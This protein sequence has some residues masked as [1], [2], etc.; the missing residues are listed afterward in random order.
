MGERGQYNFT[1]GSLLEVL[2][3]RALQQAGGG[4]EAV[5]LFFRGHV[6]KNTHA[7]RI[8]DATVEGAIARVELFAV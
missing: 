1:T 7:R 6:A 5:P 3:G 4:V 2:V 8:H